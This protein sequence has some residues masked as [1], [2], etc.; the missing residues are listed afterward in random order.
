MERVPYHFGMDLR[1]AERLERQGH[2]AE[3]EMLC[4]A[5]VDGHPRDPKGWNLL[6]SIALRSGRAQQAAELIGRAVEL[7]PRGVRYRINLAAALGTLD[8]PADALAELNAAVKLK[9]D[10]PE[11][12]NNVGVTL[13]KLRRLPEAQRAYA[14]ATELRGNYIEAHHNLGGALRKMGWLTEAAA[15]YRRALQIEPDYLPTLADLSIM[16]V[17]LAELE[18]AL[19]CIRRLIAHR[20]ANRAARSSLL[21]TLHYS[22]DYDAEALFREHV[23]WG[24]LF[25]HTVKDQ[26][27]AHENDR[28]P[29]RRLRVGYVSPDLREHTVTKFITAAIEHH[30]RDAFELFCYSDA[31][32]PD[33]ITHKLQGLAEH[34]HDTRGMKDAV[35]DQLIRKTRSTFWWT[36]A[37]TPPTTG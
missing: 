20:P 23:E 2:H 37:A 27:P 32:T 21:Y 22:P 18:D 24:R 11:L 15:A 31:E 26:I 29:D 7:D 10:V 9:K 6:G 30:D 34:W 36:S 33:K 19:A 28:N 25:C 3:A 5:F 35:L 12:W 1:E 17:D 8:R 14:R 13:E 16:L 4:R